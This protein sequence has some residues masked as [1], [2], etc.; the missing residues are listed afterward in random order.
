MLRLGVSGVY[1]PVEWLAL[2]GELRSEDL[3]HPDVVR[4]VRARAAV[5]ELTRSTSRRAAS[6]RPSARSAGAPT[7]PT[8]RSSAIPL[9]YQYL[10]SLRTDAMPATAD[11][12]LRMRARGWRSSFPIGSQAPGPGVP[13]VSGFQWDTGVQV[14]LA[15][16]T[17]RG[18]RARSPTARCRT[19]ACRTTTA[20][21][22]SPAA[23]AVTPAVGLS[24]RLGRAWRVAGAERWR[25]TPRRRSNRSAPTSSTRAITGSFAARWSGAAGRFPA[26][27]APSNTHDARRARLAGSRDATASRRGSSSRRAPIA[28]GFQT[29]HGSTI[30]T[31]GLPWDAPVTRI[32]G[33]S[34]L[35]PAAQSCRPRDG[36][37]ELARRRPRRNRTYLSGQLA[38]WF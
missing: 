36:P 38:Y 30:G 29:L 33:G 3:E 10:T 9:A 23:S 19:R 27:S 13:L 28:S 24:R 22:R 14:E 15:D 7:A 35:L 4:G 25:P 11:D 26:R 2:V 20:E 34:R 31:L 1:R 37:G 5:A 18:G 6:R 12:L 32:E 21:N 8:I 17:G 16:R